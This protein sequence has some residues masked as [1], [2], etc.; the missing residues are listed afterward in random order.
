M[1]SPS[2]TS[3]APS[4]AKPNGAAEPLQQRHVAGGPVPEPEVLPD[5]H[6]RGVQVL[7]QDVVHER[8]GR[9]PGELR[10]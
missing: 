6:E 2:A 5:H 4:T 10:A 1:P 9:Q 8:L 3:G 7:D